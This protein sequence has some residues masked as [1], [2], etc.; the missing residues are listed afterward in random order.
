MGEAAAVKFREKAKRAGTCGQNGGDLPVDTAVL[1]ILATSDL[2]MHLLPWDYYTDKPSRMRGLSQ[3]ASLISAARGEVTHSILVDNGDFLQG[4]PIGDFI[5]DSAAFS[6]DSI[7]P[8]IA[9]MNYLAYDAVCIGN[10]EFSHGLEFLDSALSNA[11]FPALSANILIKRGGTP[12]QDITL[13]PP[14]TM[15][16]RMIDIAGQPARPLT[17]GLVGLTPSQVVNWEREIL[18]GKLE[19]RGILEAARY[20][21]QQLRLQGAD[22][23]IALAHSG[24]GDVNAG[25]E[26]E[27]SVIG[28][29]QSVDFDA[30]IA[31]HTHNVFPG[32]DFGPTGILDPHQG[33]IF[34]KPVVMPGFY[35]SHLGV[36]DLELRPKPCGGWS[37]V[38]CQSKLRPVFKRTP[39]GQIRGTVPEDQTIREIARPAHDLTRRWARRK[40]GTTDVP[41]H[42]YFALVTP[43][44]SVRLVSQAQADFVR[45]ALRGS[46]WEGLPILSAAAPFRTGG[47]SG[48]ENYTQV[49]AGPISLR[50]IADLYSFPNTLIALLMSGA[51][52]CDWLERS[53]AQ[54][55]TIRPGSIDSEV[56]NHDMPG[57][58]FDLIDGLR[59]EIDLSR[60]AKYDATG[61]LI[62][63][64]AGRVVNITQGG[65]ALDPSARFILATNSYRVG[66]GGGYTMA[67]EQRVI[68]R[69]GQSIRS[70]LAT[71][72]SRLG[73][74]TFQDNPVWRFAPM[75][76]TS[77]SFLTSPVADPAACAETRFEAMPPDGTE[78]GFRRFRLSL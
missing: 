76:G 67:R 1:R 52:V 48:P 71:Y 50:N 35:G 12:A 4:S 15:I 19:V 3:L 37:L 29:A 40:I 17:I 61:R 47:R 58:D 55:R 53:A 9:A 6:A 22:L 16:T 56:I 26:Q 74:I 18:G 14:T 28:L 33:L 39:R 70:I 43:C 38:G 68:L 24:L 25:P 32:P 73:S 11:T 31:G 10:H 23:V 69:G 65:A 75:P 66:G 59:Y 2:H 30:I 7:H 8:M 78:N 36:I 13:R 41:L 5:A 63:A 64:A 49:P 60:D 27:N 77:I 46:V 72:V 20:H 44:A 42:S 34:D 51:E 45:Q 54:F 62:N 21:A 57:F